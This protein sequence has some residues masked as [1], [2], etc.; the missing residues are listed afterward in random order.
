MDDESLYTID[1]SKIVQNGILMKFIQNCFN[2]NKIIENDRITYA[3]KKFETD[4]KEYLY[5]FIRELQIYRL[6]NLCPY[7]LKFYYCDIKNYTMAFEY[8]PMN[9]LQYINTT[10]NKDKAP[11]IFK[12]ILKGLKYLHKYGVIHRDLHIKNILIDEKYII[13]ICDFGSSIIFGYA[14]KH[15][16]SNTLEITQF[17]FRA[18]EIFNEDSKYTS[19]IDIWAFGIICLIF[20]N[21]N[22]NKNPNMKI[23]KIYFECKNNNLEPPDCIKSIINKSMVI[24]PIKR[25][26]F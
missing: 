22:Y 21:Y 16:R 1:F 25:F 17:D 4:E 13:K 24:D 7:I 23:S 10:D 8:M 12:Q 2:K 14:D 5:D 15:W 18:P 9:L 11:I 3:I 20:F 19:A 6:F 26:L